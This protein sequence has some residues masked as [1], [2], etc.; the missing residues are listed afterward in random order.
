MM[1]FVLLCSLIFALL[2]NI[3]YRLIIGDDWKNI[4]IK[5]IVA[6]TVVN[7]GGNILCNMAR[8]LEVKPFSTS[9]WNTLIQTLVFTLLFTGI[10]GLLQSKRKT[11]G[12]GGRACCVIAVCCSLAFLLEMSIFNFRHYELLGGDYETV[13]YTREQMDIIDFEDGENGALYAD[14]DVETGIEILDIHREIKNMYVKVNN[15][16][17]DDVTLYVMMTDESNSGY[18]SSPKVTLVNGL[19]K[20]YYVPFSLTGETE[21]IKLRFT[22]QA[23]YDLEIESITFNQQRPLYFSYIRWM[24]VFG[25]LLLFYYLRPNSGLYKAELNFQS[26][27]QR[28]AMMVIVALQIAVLFFTAATSVDKENPPTD[29][30]QDLAVQLL[31]GHLEMSET[32]PAELETL[33]NPYDIS[34]REGLIY[35]WDMTYYDG[36][37][38]FYYGAVPAVLVYIPYYL[39]T[40][41]NLPTYLAVFIFGA[42]A[43]VALFGIIATLV[44]KYFPKTPFVLMMMSYLLVVNSSLI[45]DLLR[46]PKFY[47][48]M[49][50]SGLFF[51]TAGLFFWLNSVRSKT[52]EGSIVQK[53]YIHK[54]CAM[55]GS[56]CMAL[57]VGCRPSL[58]FVSFL[59]F[60]IFGTYV[61]RE[62]GL[63]RIIKPRT[64]QTKLNFSLQNI[65][66]FVLFC[67]PYVVVGVILMIYNAKRYGS[68]FDFG[69]N[70]QLTM[71]QTTEFKI[72]DFQ[73]LFEEGLVYL[74]HSPT[75]SMKFPYIAEGYVQNY[76]HMGKVAIITGMIGVVYNFILFFLPFA[77]KTKKFLP[78]KMETEDRKVVSRLPIYLIV[79][80]AVQL[81][82][83]I[84]KGGVVRRYMVDFMWLWL[85]AAII[86][87]YVIDEYAKK[88]KLSFFVKR[89][90]L[91]CFATGMFLHF[92]L[93][94]TGEGNAFHE[95]YPDLY[96]KIEYLCSFWL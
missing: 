14:K 5:F 73:K 41:A 6:L 55:A 21:K 11:L 45:V 17:K 66:D 22:P 35:S 8:V 57:A 76:T 18:F 69:V 87:F 89:S 50:M 75:L 71:L 52:I 46:R 27:K 54:G 40:N 33:D 70:Y 19:E 79:I 67:I 93:S 80:G 72:T 85:V 2:A 56:L 90:F 81:A 92:C 7:I 77:G 95:C 29:Y 12:I 48:V 34:Q 88:D 26:E 65:L 16:S 63:E 23:S 44:K 9:I 36:K 3:G 47:E 1:I 83:V 38:Y 30:Y 43:A 49:E 64:S 53:K 31:K 60:P 13:T 51:V 84:L 61:Y 96:H 91:I 86:I 59:A 62:F 32:P 94:M 68:P 42:G 37:Y 15:I 10:A 4:S 25:L 58:L 82:L 74:F 24:V 39:I 78:K 20:S 28:F